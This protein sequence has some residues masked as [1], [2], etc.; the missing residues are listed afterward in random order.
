MSCL[1]EY[2]EYFCINSEAFYNL[3]DAL[4]HCVPDAKSVKYFQHKLE[5]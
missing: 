2:Y 3:K 5:D 1:M 4:A